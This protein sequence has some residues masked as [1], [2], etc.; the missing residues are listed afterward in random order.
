MVRGCAGEGEP[1]RHIDPAPESQRLENRHSDV[2]TGNHDCVRSSVESPQE[3]RVGRE[4]AVD[5]QAFTLEPLD[6]RLHDAG[7]LIP[8]KPSVGGVGVQR[9]QRDPGTFEPPSRSERMIEQSKLR[10]QPVRRECRRNLA[11]G[12][13]RGGEENSK[14]RA[15][16]PRSLRMHEHSNAGRGRERLEELGLTAKG[17]SCQVERGLAD[18]TGDQSGRLAR[19]A[20]LRTRADG[21][22]GDLPRRSLGSVERPRFHESPREAGAGGVPGT[23]EHE[24]DFGTLVPEL[25]GRPVHDLGSDSPRIPEGDR[26]PS[27]QSRIST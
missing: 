19:E 15:V 26:E 3:D 21:R 16:P 6:H 17:A 24:V 10:G 14:G 18:R 9:T 27:T 13:V 25:E 23:Q 1:Q 7:L 5:G 2:V 12:Q 22:H 11:K 20:E 8:E 4:R